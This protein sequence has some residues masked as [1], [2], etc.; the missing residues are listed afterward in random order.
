[1]VKLLKKEWLFSLFLLLFFILYAYLKPSIKEIINSIDFATIRAL[2]TLL[3]I[4]TALKLSNVF[5]VLAIKTLN[6]LHTE[7]RLAFVLILLTLFLSMLLTNDITL[8]IIIPLTLA[9]NSQIKNDLTKLIIFEAIAAN[10]GSSLTPFGNPQNLFLFRQMEISVFQFVEKMSLIFLIGAITLI[11]FTN[12]TFK[13]QKI[14]PLPIAL[15][16]IDKKLFLISIFLFIAF[17]VALELS[18]VKYVLVSSIIIY[19]FIKKEVLLRF[20]Y[21]LILTFILMFIDF[22]LISKINYIKELI[23]Y[24]LDKITLFNLSIFLS[25][26]ISNVPATIFLTQLSHDYFTIAYGVNIAGNGLLIASM[27]NI[28][29]LRFLKKPYL[30]FHKYSIPFFLVTYALSVIFLDI[31]PYHF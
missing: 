18:F 12:F 31:I 8:F 20:D 27:A 2:S 17:I 3:L 13:N 29:A 7:K 1:M 28:I 24:P 25:Q 14:T 5:E 21:F 22:S 16:K 4:T 26:L 10:V 11:I 15:K 19:A 9:F 30:L 6:K 23:P